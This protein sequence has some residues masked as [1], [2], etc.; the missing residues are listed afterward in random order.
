MS[1]EAHLAASAAAFGA[2][3]A[4]CAPRASA[5]RR[6][7]RVTGF[8]GQRLTLAGLV[9]A[10]GALL[11]VETGE[12]RLARFET[13]GFEGPALVAIAL[14]DS[15]P[16]PG[17]R[18]WLAGR[19]DLV[20]F[21]PALLG[22][23]VDALGQPIDGLGAL[24]PGE[25]VPLAG[26]PLPALDRSEVTAPLFTG[27]RAIDALFTLGR[28]QRVG[29]F[30]GSGV[31]KST[32]MQQILAGAQ[33]DV[34]VAALIGE[35]G[36]E[37]AGFVDRLDPAARARTHLV[38]VPADHAAPLRVRG[39]LR[40]L[41]VAEGFRRQGAQVLLL[42]D[43]L[44][45]VAQ[46]RRELALAVGEPAGTRGWP[47]SALA[48]V[49]RVAER[50]GNDRASGGAITAILTVL[51]E[52]DDLVA[53]PI[54]EAARG[55]LDGHL[56]LDRALAARGRFPAIDLAGSLSRTMGACVAP[57]HARAAR[58]LVEA[59]AHAEANRDL[60]AMGAHV[61]GQDPAL[62]AALAAAP[63]IEAFVRQSPGDIA[64][65]PETIARLIAD[66]GVADA[67]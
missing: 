39:A 5:V 28:G 15:A 67:G 14:E 9:A 35:R 6:G 64:A 43:S 59:S 21:G 37:I 45:R 65:P 30:A 32:L 11:L 25:R 38:A 66:W 17:A 47:A 7:G 48:L 61:P 41:A 36:R 4:A 50:A 18:A 13:I 62:D 23:V 56:M 44:T 24:S 53:D 19:N 20:P 52:G 51:A 54:V 3:L 57:A 63:A 58:A 26:T 1:A 10:P 22:R 33:A 42:L 60:V 31:G 8:D 55:V 29:L 2:R 12:G 40:A 46:A 49:A 34:V 16:P 27:V